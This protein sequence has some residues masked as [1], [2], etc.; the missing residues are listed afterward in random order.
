MTKSST[1]NALTKL[2]K[3]RARQ[4]AELTLANFM[5]RGMA[6]QAAVDALLADDT[7]RMQLIAAAEAG[8]AAADAALRN[9]AIEYLS[10]HEPMPTELAA[11]VQRAL[12]K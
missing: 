6:A 10:E 3:L 7:A 11:Y 9:L 8:D 1:R 4:P 2:P 5:R 12:L